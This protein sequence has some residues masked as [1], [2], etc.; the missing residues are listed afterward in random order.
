MHTWKVVFDYLLTTC[1]PFDS[2]FSACCNV[3]YYN[4]FH[5]SLH[6][7]DPL[8]VDRYYQGLTSHLECWKA[9]HLI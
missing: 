8:L 2:V 1:I 9:L 5:L 3:L 6:C 7:S 4:E